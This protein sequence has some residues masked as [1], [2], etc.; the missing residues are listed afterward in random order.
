MR[1]LLVYKGGE[2][3][4]YPEVRTRQASGAP[5]RRSGEAA[6]E[7]AQPLRLKGWALSDFHHQRALRQLL[8]EAALVEFGHDRPFK[9]IALVQEGHA[10]GVT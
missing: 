1:L 2:P 8:I 6:P 7:N 9:L 3:V 10:E 5:C 4:S